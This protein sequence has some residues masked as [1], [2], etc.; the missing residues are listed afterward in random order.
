MAL[1]GGGGSAATKYHVG[2]KGAT[3][4]EKCK[5]SFHAPV[6]LS[7]SYSPLVAH[8]K[9]NAMASKSYENRTYPREELSLMRLTDPGTLD[10]RLETHPY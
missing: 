4:P 10:T 6:I 3:K 1:F 2:G 5:V 8:H 7:P 9:E